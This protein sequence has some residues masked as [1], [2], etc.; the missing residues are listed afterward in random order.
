MSY[1]WDETDLK[2]HKVDPIVLSMIRIDKTRAFQRRLKELDDQLLLNS[3]Q[4]HLIFGSQYAYTYNSQEHPD[5]EN[6]T[7]FRGDF[8]AAG[9]S[10][11]AFHNWS[12]AERGADDRYRIADIG[13]AQFIKADVDLRFY[14]RINSKSSIALRWTGGIG[15]PYGNSEALPFQRSFF[16]G[17]SNGLRA[18]RIRTIGPGSYTDSTFSLSFDKIGDIKLEGNLEYRFDLIDPVKGAF[19]LDAGNIWLLEKN[20]KRPGGHFRS[21]EFLNEIAVGG[22][23]G[24]RIDLNFFIVRLDLAIPLKDPEL[25]VGERWIFQPKERINSARRRQARKVPGQDFSPYRPRPN[26]NLGIGYP[27]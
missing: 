5:Q 8:E 17:G 16:G 3:Y 20:E 22:G 27:F 25:P 1:R 12:G 4:D 2:K 7:F 10:L 24:L 6:I 9:N 14:H 11:Q 19:F 21:E 26:L 13:Y 15:V 23:F 18:W